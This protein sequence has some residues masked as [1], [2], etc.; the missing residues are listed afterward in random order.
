MKGVILLAVIH[1][2][3][4]YQSEK[5]RSMI[6]SRLQETA[7]YAGNQTINKLPEVELWQGGKRSGISYA[8][9]PYYGRIVAAGR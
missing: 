1:A 2:L 5:K 4:M 7:V 9:M 8:F 6:K 3:I